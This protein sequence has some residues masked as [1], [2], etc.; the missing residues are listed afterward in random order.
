MSWPHMVEAKVME[1]KDAATSYSMDSRTGQIKQE[2]SE[3]DR[4]KKSY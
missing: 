4:G 1:V 3:D 2:L